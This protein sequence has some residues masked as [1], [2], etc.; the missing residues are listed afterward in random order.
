MSTEV[1]E[2]HPLIQALP[3][4]DK[5]VHP[6]AMMVSQAAAAAGCP[7]VVEVAKVVVPFVMVMQP[8]ETMA[9]STAVLVAEELNL[10]VIVMRRA[11][12]V[13]AVTQV[14][15]LREMTILAVVAAH[16]T[17]LAHASIVLAAAVPIT[18]W[19]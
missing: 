12:A 1:A 6:L 18:V 14:G 16:P 10:G 5:A 2:T 11:A 9:P 4:P 17:M 8:A 3:D 13:A 7:L 15:A 19:S